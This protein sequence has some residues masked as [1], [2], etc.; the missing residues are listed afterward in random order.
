[1]YNINVHTIYTS[2]NTKEKIGKF[3]E[4]SLNSSFEENPKD[5][6]IVNSIISIDNVKVNV[7][8]NK[9]LLKKH[10]EKY[11]RSHQKNVLLKNK[12]DEL[13]NK[14]DEAINRIPF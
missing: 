12:Y 8:N 1:M 11:S 3:E 2:K 4:N 5:N 13:E 6:N 14:Y 10:Y 9:P 7:K